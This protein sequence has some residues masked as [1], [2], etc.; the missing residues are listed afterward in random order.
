MCC[1]ALSPVPPAG[2]DY[3]RAHA[4]SITDAIEFG[5]IAT[6]KQLQDAQSCLF[7]SGQGGL[8]W[9]T[10]VLIKWKRESCWCVCAVFME[11]EIVCQLSI[12]RR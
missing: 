10:D 3:L 6:G 7:V 2:V 12:E 11:N 9:Q 5:L 1:L 4:N 8:G